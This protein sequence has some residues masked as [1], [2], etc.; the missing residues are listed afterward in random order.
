MYFLYNYQLIL[1]FTGFSHLI[2][3]Q[4]I[5]SYYFRYDSAWEPYS[6]RT[7]LSLCTSHTRHLALCNWNLLAHY[8]ISKT[9]EPQVP[10]MFQLWN[11]IKHCSSIYFLRHLHSILQ[12]WLE[13]GKTCTTT[14]KFA[15]LEWP[16]YNMSSLWY[17]K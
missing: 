17:S 10:H 11:K 8:K 4:D 3:T 7:N 16:V 5:V 1:A 12:L 6:Q 9:N 15:T 14:H 2:R 13:Q